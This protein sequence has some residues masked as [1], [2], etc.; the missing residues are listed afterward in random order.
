MHSHDSTPTLEA[1]A[2]ATAGPAP[3]PDVQRH[4]PRQVFIRD[5]RFPS[6]RAQVLAWDVI[7]QGTSDVSTMLC[8]GALGDFFLLRRSGDQPEIAARIVPMSSERAALWFDAHPVRFAPR[9]DLR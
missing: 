6:D 3:S 4:D 5:A 7:C 9:D 2:P 1:N 8:R